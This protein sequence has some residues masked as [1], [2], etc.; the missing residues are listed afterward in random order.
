MLQSNNAW[1]DTHAN[2]LFSHFNTSSSSKVW[3][4]AHK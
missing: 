3:F 2:T 1:L 4:W